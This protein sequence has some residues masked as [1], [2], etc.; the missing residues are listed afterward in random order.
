MK[1]V[2]LRAPLLTNSGYGVHSRQIFEWLLTRKDFNVTTQTLK[3]GLTPWLINPQD[4]EGLV[5]KIMQRAKNID[6]QKFDITFQVQLPDEWDENL[7]FVNVGVTA[8]VETDKCNPAWFDKFKKMDHVIVPS[9]FTKK[10]ITDTFGTIFDSKVHVVPEWFNPLLEEGVNI[11][12]RDSRFDFDTDFN[13]LTIGTLTSTDLNSD[14]KNLINTLG[15]AIE[16]LDGIRGTGIVVKTSFGR[17]SVQDREITKS[18][19]DQVKKAF[20]KSDF[21]KIHLLHGNMKNEEVASI[22]QSNKIK[23]YISATRGEGYGLPLI[24]AAASGIPVIATNWSGHL[25]FLE[26]SFLKVDHTLQP[27]PENRIDNRIFVPGTKWADPQKESFIQ[28]INDL[29]ENLK[30]HQEVA[31]KH[32][33][34]VRHNFSREKICKKYD[35][36]LKEC[37]NL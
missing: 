1:N 30:K 11:K 22:Y 6:N 20:R 35:K 13:L 31:Q 3:W 18:V 24:E 25:D 10:V 5:G 15:W 2:L 14:R 21:P 34:H 4:E 28:S 17:G 26:D 7:G 32:K 33:K 23:G 12:S 27:V 9:R 16:A 8:L 37:F 29:R 36:F 19:I